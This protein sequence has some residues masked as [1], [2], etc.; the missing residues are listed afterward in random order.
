MLLGPFKTDHMGDVFQGGLYGS[1][2]FE[3]CK[4]QGLN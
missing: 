1:A 2:V 4:V 3:A